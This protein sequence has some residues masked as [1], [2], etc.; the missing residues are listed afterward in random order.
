VEV[1]AEGMDGLNLKPD[2]PDDEA[3]HR[4]TNTAAPELLK[5]WSGIVT[6]RFT[7]LF[8]GLAILLVSAG[9]ESDTRQLLEEA[10]L[11]PE[12]R[13][14]LG[15]GYMNFLKAAADWWTYIGQKPSI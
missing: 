8:Q 1:L 5:S 12:A 3:I 6:R 7:S 13:K 9:L 4:A 11:S 2:G 10:K 14:I 15:S